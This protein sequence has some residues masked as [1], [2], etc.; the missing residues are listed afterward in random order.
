M[1]EPLV[2]LALP[3]AIAAAWIGIARIVSWR[4]HR[5][6]YTASQQSCEAQIIAPAQSPGAANLWLP[7]YFQDNRSAVIRKFG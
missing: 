5:R 7:H 3:G 2:A 1:T 4:F 6:D